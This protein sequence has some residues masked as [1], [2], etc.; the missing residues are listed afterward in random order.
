MKDRNLILLGL[1]FL[2]LVVGAGVNRSLEAC[3]KMVGSP[4]APGIREI[5]SENAPTARE[6]VRELAG[7]GQVRVKSFYGS[8]SPRL[9]QFTEVTGLKV[10]AG[11]KKILTTVRNGAAEWSRRAADVFELMNKRLEKLSGQVVYEKN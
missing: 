2:V 3:N 1:L 4:L 6:R 7:Y 5:Y 8:Y 9:V 11:A 10:G